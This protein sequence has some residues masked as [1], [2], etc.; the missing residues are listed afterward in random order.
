MDNFN[1]DKLKK[2]ME[3]YKI[4]NLNNAVNILND[5]DKE[6]L[7]KLS[8][9]LC[10]EIYKNDNI[11]NNLIGEDSSSYNSSTT[12]D[13]VITPNSEKNNSS[14]DSSNNKPFNT[15]S[16]KSSEHKEI[17]TTY[18]VNKS[19]T[20]EGYPNI[21]NYIIVEKIG[22][23]AYGK[24]Y[25]AI[26]TGTNKPY[27]MKVIMKATNK[28][29]NN[30]LHVIQREVAIMKK[31]RHKN[32]ASLIEVIDDK[33]ENRIYLVMDYVD[34]GI[35][36]K[37]K[38]HC[39]YEK[40]SEK[41]TKKYMQQITAGLQYLHNHNIVHRDIKPENILSDNN[42]NIYLSDFGV[43]EIFCEKEMMTTMRKGTLLF[44]SPELFCSNE[45]LN[46]VM[47]DVWA[48]GVTLFAMLYGYLPFNGESFSEIK[49]NV[50]T[51]DPI[52]PDLATE[53]QKDLLSKIL[54]KDPFKRISLSEIRMHEFMKKKKTIFS[55][56]TKYLDNTNLS[57]IDIQNAFSEKYSKDNIRDS[58][59]E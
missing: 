3:L 13:S 57:K 50:L 34:N 49:E 51:N 28:L 11:D 14:S 39:L 42:G 1:K 37:K 47:I 44:F 36:L 46:G 25:L 5:L 17:K 2:V 32:I 31:I 30:E 29:K 43:S 20:S 53:I 4:H 8:L 6:E 41:K 16:L 38:D 12:D 56:K 45:K 26:D 15:S 48:L 10:Q 22:K 35:I 55:E 58:D 52:Y 40:I 54:C 21:N 24:V 23:G 27:A 7:L 59:V 18:H 33:N 9:K 19:K